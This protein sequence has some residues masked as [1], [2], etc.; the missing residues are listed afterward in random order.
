M[1]LLV[2]GGGFLLGSIAAMCCMCLTLI[3]KKDKTRGEG[4]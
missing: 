1:V 2:F 3:Q 4:Q